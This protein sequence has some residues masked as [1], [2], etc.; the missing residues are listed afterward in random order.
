MQVSGTCTPI[1]HY[2]SRALKI[3]ICHRFWNLILNQEEGR[4]GRDG[5]PCVPDTGLGPAPISRLLVRRII[6]QGWRKGDRHACRC[7]HTRVQECTRNYRTRQEEEANQ[8][9]A[10]ASGKQNPFGLTVGTRQAAHEAKR[11][12]ILGVPWTPWPGDWLPWP[13]LSPLDPPWRSEPLGDGAQAWKEVVLVKT[14]FIA[15]D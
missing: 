3:G 4:G 5:W 8:G 13:S 12:V 11:A 9:R 15:S 2:L 7:A 14:F 10:W 6:Q 1:L